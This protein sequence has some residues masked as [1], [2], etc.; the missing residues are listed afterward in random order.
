MVILSSLYSILNVFCLKKKKYNF[1]INYFWIKY[2]T[3]KML[4]FFHINKTSLSYTYKLYYQH[5]ILNK[6]IYKRRL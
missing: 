5:L 1:N 2:E 6:N 3:M 4:T